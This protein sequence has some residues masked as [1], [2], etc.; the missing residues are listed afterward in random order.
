M[1]WL[2]DP[3][4]NRPGEDRVLSYAGHSARATSTFVERELDEAVAAVAP[5][6][7]RGDFSTPGGIVSK[8]TYRMAFL[9]DNTYADLT[10][11]RG[12]CSPRRPR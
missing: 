10:S 9:T 7:D 1:T 12:T 3:A 8:R 2:V 11:A 4:Y 5:V 6:A